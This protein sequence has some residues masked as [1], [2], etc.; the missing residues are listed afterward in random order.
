MENVRLRVGSGARENVRL[1]VRG[2]RRIE[3]GGERNV[4]GG[5]RE[6][7]RPG[8]RRERDLVRIGGNLPASGIGESQGTTMVSHRMWSRGGRKERGNCTTLVVKVKRNRS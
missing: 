8:A 1:R 5:A 2:R 7:V 4:E 3:R 6:N